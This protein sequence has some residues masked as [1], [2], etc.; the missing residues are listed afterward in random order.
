MSGK[1]G[2][3]G[4]SKVHRLMQEHRADSEASRNPQ[5][6]APLGKFDPLYIPHFTFNLPLKQR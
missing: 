6:E 4:G 1:A 2:R 3:A 5:D